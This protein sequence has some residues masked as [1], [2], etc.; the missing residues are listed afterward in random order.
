MIRTKLA[1]CVWNDHRPSDASICQIITPAKTITSSH[2]VHTDIASSK[3]FAVSLSSRPDQLSLFLAVSLS[4]PHPQK[5]LSNS[6]VPSHHSV[7]NPWKPSHSL[8]EEVGEP[9]K[10]KEERQTNKWSSL[11]ERR[12]GSASCRARSAYDDIIEWGSDSL[13]MWHTST[14]VEHKLL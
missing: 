5:T 10:D 14:E 7:Q 4:A 8:Q 1:I 6:G 2:D 13:I 3:L 9:A 11:Q 12:S